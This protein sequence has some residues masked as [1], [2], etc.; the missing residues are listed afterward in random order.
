LPSLPFIRKIADKVSDNVKI[1]GFQAATEGS[2]AKHD[3]AGHLRLPGTINFQSPPNGRGEVTGGVA[4]KLKING[5]A[6]AL[7]GS[8]VSTCNDI[9]V[10]DNCAILAFGASFPMPDIIH[11]KNAK[12]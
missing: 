11:P 3:D 5:K 7:V 12:A 10:R 1:N 8:A 9:G 4:P 6:A 2:V